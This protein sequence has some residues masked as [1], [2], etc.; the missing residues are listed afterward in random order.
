MTV[1]MFPQA[2]TQI[3]DMTSPKKW[4]LRNHHSTYTYYCSNKILKSR[5]NSGHLH[6]CNIIENCMT[7]GCNRPDSCCCLWR[8]DCGA[9]IEWKCLGECCAMNSPSSAVVPRLILLEVRVT[10]NSLQKY[11]VVLLTLYLATIASL[12]IMTV[13]SRAIVTPSTM[14]FLEC[15]ILMLF[16]GNSK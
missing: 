7:R 16:A 14:W 5:D 13:L 2:T 1:N 11:T 4:N 3:A 12:T 6:T 9:C 8:S 15:S 10:R